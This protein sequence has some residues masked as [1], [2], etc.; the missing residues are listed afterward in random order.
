M[1]CKKAWSLSAAHS[2]AHHNDRRPVHVRVSPA[3]APRARQAP[4][5]R[6]CSMFR[7]ML[8]LSCLSPHPP[9]HSCRLLPLTAQPVAHALPLLRHATAARSV[10]LILFLP[11]ASCLAARV[12]PG[13]PQGSTTSSDCWRRRTGAARCGSARR[14]TGR[15]L[16]PPTPVVPRP[17][18]WPTVSS[19]GVAGSSAAVSTACGVVRLRQ[20]APE[21]AVAFERVSY[22]VQASS[23]AS[24]LPC[25]TPGPVTRLPRRLRA[26]GSPCG[27]AADAPLQPRHHTLLPRSLLW[28]GAAPF[29]RA[30]APPPRLAAAPLDRPIVRV[31]SLPPRR[32][33]ERNRPRSPCCPRRRPAA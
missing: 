13:P 28:W 16:A 21:T 11:S 2:P 25:S 8:R 22:F 15:L 32:C 10:S 4:L 3:A 24:P 17:S 23:W 1:A 12:P 18:M 29:Q 9:P 31:G 30:A 26:R 20:L 14:A 7:Y 27:P 33:A 6:T 5:G 19:F